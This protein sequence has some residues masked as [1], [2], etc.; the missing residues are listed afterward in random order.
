MGETRE[1]MVQTT[2]G[3][4][5]TEESKRGSKRKKN[6]VHKG[7]VAGRAR[8]IDMMIVTARKSRDHEVKEKQI[9][10]NK[11]GGR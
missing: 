6:R 5:Q 9:K 11:S 7:S 2:V 10:N 4:K 1:R 8:E 3:R